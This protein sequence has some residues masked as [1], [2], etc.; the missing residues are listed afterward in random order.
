MA[1]LSQTNRQRAPHLADAEDHMHGL[2]THFI[3][4]DDRASAA[5]MAAA[6]ML[7]I[8]ASNERRE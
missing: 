7:P 3:D 1:R 6:V 5:R 2:G 4:P 8:R